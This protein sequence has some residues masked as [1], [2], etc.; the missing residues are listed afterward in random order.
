M[1]FFDTVE[2]IPEGVGFAM[3][4]KVHLMWLSIFIAVCTIMCVLYRKMGEVARKRTR[5]IL[6]SLIVLDEIYKTIVLIACGTHNATYLPLHLCSINIVTIA[7]HSIKPTKAL[8]NYLYT[9]CIPAAIMALLTP[10]WTTL[11]LA[12]FMHIHS[13]TVHIMLALYPIMLTVGGDIVPNVKQLP[14]CVGVLAIMAVPALI[15]NLLFDTNFMFLMETETVS[16]L[17]LFEELFGSHLWAF[18]VLIPIILAVMQLPP[19]VMQKIK[20]KKA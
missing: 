6:A 16:I 3:F 15:V 9:I 11:P 5:I 12:N 1:Y 17:I 7:I 14:Q 4:D 10:S 2:T 20:L 18:P 8:G 19:F 13:F